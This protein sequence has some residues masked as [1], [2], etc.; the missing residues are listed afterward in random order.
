M[1][2]IFRG[3]DILEINVEE[4]IKKINSKNTEVNALDIL[5]ERYVK[6]KI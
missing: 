2:Y 3:N 5:N 6:I 4:I 1:K